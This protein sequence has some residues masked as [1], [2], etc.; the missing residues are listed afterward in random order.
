[1]HRASSR[2]AHGNHAIP[3]DVLAATMAFGSGVHFLPCDD[4]CCARSCNKVRA[5][6]PIQAL[7][8]FQFECLR[9]SAL[10]REAY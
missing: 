8:A 2:R 4:L 10:L 6:A 3:M 9:I 7:I 5:I 1:M